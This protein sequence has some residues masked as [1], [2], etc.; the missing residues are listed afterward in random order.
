MPTRQDP[1]N[2]GLA[3]CLLALTSNSLHSADGEMML[4]F[5]RPPLKHHGSAI[6]R[7]TQIGEHWGCLESFCSLNR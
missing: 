5:S 7:S 6:T 4:R 1:L 3:P 2:L